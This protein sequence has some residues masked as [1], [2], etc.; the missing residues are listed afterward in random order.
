V[1]SAAA[2][3]WAWRRRRRRSKSKKKEGEKE[4]RLVPMQHFEKKS[5]NLG[6]AV[7]LKQGSSHCLPCIIGGTYSV[8]ILKTSLTNIFIKKLFL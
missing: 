2:S 8:Q 7:I 1:A 3:S 6:G 5:L 4:Y